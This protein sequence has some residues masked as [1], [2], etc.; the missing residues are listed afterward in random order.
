MHF[1]QLFATVAVFLGLASTGLAAPSEN[2]GFLRTRQ[3]GLRGCIGG[4]ISCEYPKGRCAVICSADG[5]SLSSVCSCP[6][7]QADN[8]YTGAECIDVFR[9]AAFFCGQEL[10]VLTF[11]V[12]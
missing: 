7:G 5:S 10:V 1:I 3:N 12:W 6:D 9:A 8:P 2:K 11:R 4:A